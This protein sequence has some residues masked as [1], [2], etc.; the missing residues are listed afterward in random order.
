M[1]TSY[2]EKKTREAIQATKGNRQL[3][4]HLL[5]HW[6]ESDPQLLGA[7]IRPILRTLCMLAVDR[8]IRRQRRAQQPVEQSELPTRLSSGEEAA[9]EA[10]SGRSDYTLTSLRN[11]ARRPPQ[12]SKRHERS[13]SA[14]VSSFKAK[15]KG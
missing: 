12:A 13:M 10:L 3:A 11:P 8:Y 9:V 7:L 14:L 15:K 1:T 6:A 2:L 5:Q 4:T